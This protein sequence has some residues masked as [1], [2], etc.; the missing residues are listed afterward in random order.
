VATFSL[1]GSDFQRVD[2]ML[3]QNGP[4][5][6]Y[7]HHDALDSDVTWLRDHGYQVAEFDCR[8][9]ADEQAMHEAFAAKLAFPDY[10]GMNLDALNDC[11]ADVDVP[12][13]G[14]LVLVLER[15]DSFASHHRKVTQ[16]VLDILAENARRFLL[17]GRRLFVL[18]RSDDPRISFSPV[19]ATAVSWNP[20][21]WLDKNR[22]V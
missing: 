12:V 14:G 21:E 4:V 16:A 8:A 11:I 5:S 13:D 9:W 2:W 15:V 20:K 6:L 22:G 18:A 1:D 19:G 3:L 7:F 17:F 10:Y